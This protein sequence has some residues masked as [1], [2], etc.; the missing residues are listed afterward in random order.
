M[1]LSRAALETWL[2][3]H[4]PGY[5]GPLTIDQFFGGQSNPTYRLITPA[6]EYVLRKQPGGTLLPG[7]HAIDREYR[8]M[9]AL[10][11]GPVPVPRPR[12]YCDDAT[13]LATPFFIMDFVPGRVFRDAR[14]PELSKV[15][16]TLLYDDFNR[17]LAALHGLDW[18]AAGLTGY[19]RPGGYLG[20][21]LSVWTRQYR[22]SETHAIPAMEKLIAWLPAHLPADD[23]T[24]LVHGD[25]RL[26]NMLVAADRP[27]I[28]GVVDWERSPLGHPLADLAHSCMLY[29]LPP[30]ALGGF[31][32]IDRDALGIPEEAD[33]LA[34]YCQ[35]TGQTGI[36]DWPFHV[37]FAL[38]RMAAILQGVYK[39]AL[40]GHGSSPDGVERG[41]Q[42]A[43]CA[44]AGWAAVTGT[45]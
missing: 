8:V 5:A 30:E 14:L 7:A 37:G 6:A 15:E 34:T 38:F 1:S 26:E 35:R 3:R 41:A 42:A 19:G 16:R 29:H 45:V 2:T 44:E 22:A 18:A 31:L 43:L 23:R 13:V 21:Q 25:F 33:F 17:V 28:V 27:A 32:G 39:R 4:L 10:A 9:S 24:T 40:D 20:R 11:G 36:A 12:I